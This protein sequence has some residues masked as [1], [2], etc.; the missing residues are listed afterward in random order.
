VSAR[1][2][3]LKFGGTSV[4]TAPA[5]GSLGRGVVPVVGGFVGATEAGGTA[6]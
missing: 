5:L 4:G 6:A 1:R 2:R 3:V